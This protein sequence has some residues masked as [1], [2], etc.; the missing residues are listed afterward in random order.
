MTLQPRGNTHPVRIAAGCASSTPGRQRPRGPVS[1][2]NDLYNGLYGL[3]RLHDL[4]GLSPPLH[5]LY[6]RCAAM[7]FSRRPSSGLSVGMVPSLDR[8]VVVAQSVLCG[9]RY[10][11]RWFRYFACHIWHAPQPGS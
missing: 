5:P 3:H 4:H 7:V 10:S 2:Y 11:P 6:I 9:L 1:L 8:Y